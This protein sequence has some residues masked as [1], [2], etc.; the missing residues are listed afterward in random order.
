M[1]NSKTINNK[2]LTSYDDY[3]FDGDRWVKVS[4]YIELLELMSADVDEY[5]NEKDMVD[6]RKQSNKEL[7][8][9]TII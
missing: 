8:Q 9:S 1:I 2:E 3:V 5:W 6:N 7:G 4:D